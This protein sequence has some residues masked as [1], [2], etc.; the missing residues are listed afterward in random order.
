MGGVLSFGIN[1]RTHTSTESLG[2]LIKKKNPGGSW[3]HLTE[4]PDIR[5]ALAEKAGHDSEPD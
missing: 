1:D 5:P 4:C 3:A 2:K